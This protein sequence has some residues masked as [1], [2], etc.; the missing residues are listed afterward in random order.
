MRNSARCRLLPVVF[1]VLAASSPAIAV[2]A[3]EPV[4]SIGPDW[5]ASFE[6]VDGS[7]SAY[8]QVLSS[9]T[10]AGGVARVIRTTEWLDAPHV[11]DRTFIEGPGGGVWLHK[12]VDHTTGET[13]V[14]DPPLYCLPPRSLPGT[15]WDV[16]TTKHVTCAGV[17]RSQTE[18]H[19]VLCD[20]MTVVS[21]VGTFASFWLMDTS[22]NGDPLADV[23]LAPGEGFVAF[24]SAE[25]SR[26]Y[27]LNGSTRHGWPPGFPAGQVVPLRFAW[28]DGAEWVVQTVTSVEQEIGSAIDTL[29]TP[30]DYDMAVAH[31]PGGVAVSQSGVRGPEGPSVAAAADSATRAVEDAI[32]SMRIDLNIGYDGRFRGLMQPAD[33]AARLEKIM[34]LADDPLIPPRMQ[35]LV[36]SLYQGVGPAEIEDRLRTEWSYLVSAWAGRNLA[37]GESVIVPTEITHFLT[38]ELHPATLILSLA[39]LVPCDEAGNAPDCAELHLVTWQ[40]Q[41][42]H[43][44]DSVQGGVVL[45][46]EPDGLVPH[47]MTLYERYRSEQSRAAEM[48]GLNRQ[49]WYRFGTGSRGG[50]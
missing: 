6:S 1:M 38:G 10:V 31:L 21:P 11:R 40:V 13:T 7:A 19:A 12:V 16:Q 36:R 35:T 48:T 8:I 24:D 33:V 14:Y 17:T 28:P 26:Q 45:V 23:F 20:T 5:H 39:R 43:A 42:G 3:T 9:E 18:N 44:T 34:G 49:T 22:E 37:V 4:W 30:T 47:R 15:A 41:G 46:S 2:D 25:T 50:R 32:A 27:V 29:S